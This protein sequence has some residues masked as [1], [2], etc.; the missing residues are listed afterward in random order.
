MAILP[1]PLG[2]SWSAV[3]EQL[4]TMM[5]ILAERQVT[6]GVLGAK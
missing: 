3:R 2:H 1:T 4:P 5:L 6:L